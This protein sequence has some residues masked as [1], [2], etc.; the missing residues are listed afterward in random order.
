MV[1]QAWA[2]IVGFSMSLKALNQGTSSWC[3]KAE[4]RH[5]GIRRWRIPSLPFASTWGLQ[6]IRQHFLTLSRLI[7]F[8]Q[9]TDLIV[10]TSYK[11]C[12][13]STRNRICPTVSAWHFDTLIDTSTIQSLYLRLR[14]HHGKRGRRTVRAREQLRK[15]SVFYMWQGSIIYDILSSCLNKTCTVTTPADMPTWIGEVSTKLH[16]LMKSY[17]Q[18]MTAK[19][20][21]KISKHSHRLANPRWSALNTYTYKQH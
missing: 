15:D 18:L 7:I 5:P 14:E 13:R 9:S 4:D 11:Y 8:T 2:L 16:P 1:C 12:Y 20:G 19:R 3:L 17:R 21:K 10:I 6:W